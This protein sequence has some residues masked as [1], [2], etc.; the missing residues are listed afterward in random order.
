MLDSVDPIGISAVT[1]IICPVC[2]LR[3]EPKRSNQKYC[4]S[5]CQKNAARG[6]RKQESK[7]RNALHFRRALD[8]A[9]LIYTAPTVQRLG[10]MKT[11]LEAAREHDAVYVVS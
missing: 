5:S 8:L 3:F 9:E 10:I 1:E 11:I 4:A 2:K 7:A 6:N